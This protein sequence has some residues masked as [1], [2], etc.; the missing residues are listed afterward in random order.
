MKTLKLESL[1]LRGGGG[2]GGACPPVEWLIHGG[3]GG[4]G[5]KG[6]LWSAFNAIIFYQKM[7]FL[8]IT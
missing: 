4:S 8:D 6:Y 3:S 5:R 2:V 7:N 1:I